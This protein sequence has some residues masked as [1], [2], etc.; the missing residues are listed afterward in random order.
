MRHSTFLLAIFS[1]FILCSISA[2]RE[3][4][5]AE[6]KSFIVEYKD[7]AVKEMHLSG[8]PASITLA[9]FILETDWGRGE[10]F[11]EA[12]AGFGIKCKENWTGETHYI[13]D[14]DKVNGKLIESCFRKYSSIEET[15]ADHSD[16]LKN[17][18]YYKPLFLLENHDYKGW[19]YGL[20]DCGYATDTDYS[21]K[22]IRL[23]ETY[24]LHLYDYQMQNSHLLVVETPQVQVET[25]VVVPMPRP[26]VSSPVNR[27]A[28][29]ENLTNVVIELVAP[30]YA[31]IHSASN[32][33]AITPITRRKKRRALY[34]INPG[35]RRPVAV[36]AP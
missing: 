4:S 31:G 24:G 35:H 2:D 12:K 7:L 28:R 18:H 16:F 11:V 26:S 14:D 6:R 22:L 1:L 32:P 8:I 25:A 29:K 34:K 3:I 10:L 19:A 17:R 5:F 13:K 36:Y 20:K 9:Q 30:N 23:I 15:F 33:Q 27:P 21:K